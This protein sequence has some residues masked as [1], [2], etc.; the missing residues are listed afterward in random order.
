MVVESILLPTDTFEHHCLLCFLK[1]SLY[2]ALVINQ[3]EDSIHSSQLDAKPICQ[4]LFDP[5]Y[6]A[7]FS[8]HNVRIPRL[9]ELTSDNFNSSCFPPKMNGMG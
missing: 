9:P 2:R 7:M 4:S 6:A 3:N 8:R 1:K 5:L